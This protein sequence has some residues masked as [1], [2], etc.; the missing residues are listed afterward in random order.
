MLGHKMQEFTGEVVSGIGHASKRMSAGSIALGLYENETG[1]EL[2]PGSLNIDIGQEIDISEYSRQIV[3]VDH[4]GEAV[5]YITPALVNNLPGFAV[6]NKRAEEGSG[7]H[8]KSIIEIISSY[9]LRNEL[10]LKDGDKVIV[11]F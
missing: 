4:E 8:P 3:R 9:H 6:R 1:Q 5:I 7:T 2:I 11:R 10:K